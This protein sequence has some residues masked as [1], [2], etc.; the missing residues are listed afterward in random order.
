MMLGGR[1]SEEIFFGRVTTGAQDDLQKI[2]E[3]AYSQ[4]FKYFVLEIFLNLRLFKVVS[5]NSLFVSISK[6][7]LLAKPYNWI[8]LLMLVIDLFTDC[9]VRYEQESRSVVVYRGFKFSKTIF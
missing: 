4:V 3:M 5:E 6:S 8:V 2:T 7:H 1:V 9:E